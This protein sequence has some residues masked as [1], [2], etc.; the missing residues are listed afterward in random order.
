MPVLLH[1]K[2]LHVRYLALNLP[3]SLDLR[4]RNLNCVVSHPVPDP[5]AN[6]GAS[7]QLIALPLISS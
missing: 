2:D 1:P 6:Y 3:R 7:Q 4:D 5:P